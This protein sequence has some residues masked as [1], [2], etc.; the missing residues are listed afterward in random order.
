MAAHPMGLVGVAGVEV[1]RRL[2]AALR[3]YFWAAGMK[4]AAAG[5]GQ[6]AGYV[7]G[8]DGAV[9]ALLGVGQWHGGH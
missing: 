9:A 1:W 3:H 5:H 4:R 2:F 8:Q 7:A 6:W